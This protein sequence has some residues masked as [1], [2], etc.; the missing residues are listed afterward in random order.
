MADYTYVTGPAGETSAVEGW[1]S[2]EGDTLEV[3]GFEKQVTERGSTFVK[4]PGVL[5]KSVT[6]EEGDNPKAVALK[7]LRDR[8][9][10][11]RGYPGATGPLQYPDLG[12]F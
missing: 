12:W 11:T 7:V 8:A 1:Y 9:L 5:L 2:V 4:Q 10:A 6:L 3:Y